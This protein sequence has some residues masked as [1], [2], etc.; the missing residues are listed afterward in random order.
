MIRESFWSHWPLRWKLVALLAPGLLAMLVL[1]SMLVL[2]LHHDAAT[3]R[4]AYAGIAPLRM[5]QETLMRTQQHRGLSASWLAGNEQA[6]PQR[7]EREAQLVKAMAEVKTWVNSD[8]SH[9]AMAAEW[10]AMQAAWDS[11]LAGVKEKKLQAKQAIS[12]HTALIQQQLQV[13][14]QLLYDSE[15]ILDPTADGYSLVVLAGQQLPNQTERLGQLRARGSAALAA[16]S[17]SPQ[18][19]ATITGLIAQADAAAKLSNQALQHALDHNTELAAALKEP[20]ETARREME[21]L[22]AL[23]RAELLDA[24]NL[25]L[26]PNQ[27]YA[28]A[29]RAIDAQFKLRDVVTNELGA[30]LQARI[31]HLTVKEWSVAG[32][33]L[34]MMGLSAWLSL[35]VSGQMLRGFRHAVRVSEGLAEGNLGVPITAQGKDE[36]AQLLRAMATTQQA[37]RAIVHE[38]RQGVD[39]VSTASEQIAQGNGDLESRTQT[40]TANVARTSS[41]M[42]QMTASVRMN[43]DNAAHA[44]TLAAQANAMAGRGGEVVR[45][46]VGTMDNI[47]A[48]STRIGDI[49]GVIDGIAFQTNILALNAAVEAAR[50]GEQG[51]GFAVVAGEVRSLAKRSADAAQEIKRLIAESVERV[52]HGSAAVHEAGRTI[53]GMVAQVQ[54]VA[55]LIGNIT[56]ASQ[57]QRAGIQDVSDA[58][59]ELDD[60]TR[61]N[62]S[63][64]EEGAAAA[65]SLREQ[66]EHLLQQV[67][68][69]RLESAR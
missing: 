9:Q 17:L 63:L 19:A 13:M 30:L 51:R 61:Q 57:Q 38:V 2:Q 1:G 35:A 54:Q 29:T 50:A 3:A 64:V 28:A 37:L 46:V 18:D 53:D 14:D 34:L 47:Q 22:V 55:E 24:E 36:L 16:K 66:A 48:S 6:G 42:Q 40:Q 62:A 52:A 32:A 58:L 39:N 56:V 67:S 7:A 21:A 4:K 41:T 33:V 31:H 69:F 23:V 20:A 11:T 49:I 60:T 27:Y 15:L 65:R 59:T 68:V 45:Q 10:D 26:D 8:P 5:I 43:A 12:R 44:N 25:A